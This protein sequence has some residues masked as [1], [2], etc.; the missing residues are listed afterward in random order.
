M[1]AGSCE[2]STHGRASESTDGRAPASSRVV[3]DQ[4]GV[5]GS[6]GACHHLLE[7]EPG[8]YG[9]MTRQRL[10]TSQVTTCRREEGGI[11]GAGAFRV[12][13]VAAHRVPA[14]RGVSGP[15]VSPALGPHTLGPLLAPPAYGVESPWIMH[16]GQP[17]A[18]GVMGIGPGRLA[19]AQLSHGRHV[20]RERHYPARRSSARRRPGR[21]VDAGASSW[22]ES[23]YTRRP[24]ESVNQS[25]PHGQPAAARRVSG[26]AA[27][28]S[29]AR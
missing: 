21:P 28:R 5:A 17:T 24:A 9:Q 26:A 23:Q 15:R 22:S 29:L 19:G 14:G 4:Q 13:R 7:E 27:G 1:A 6:S 11:K 8:S 20:G 10:G 18:G 12:G 16:I 25:G 2:R 3:G